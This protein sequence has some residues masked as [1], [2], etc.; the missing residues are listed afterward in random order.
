M[1]KKNYKYMFLTIYLFL[2]TLSFSDENINYILKN[3]DKPFTGMTSFFR[4]RSFYKD[5]KPTG[6]W[7][8]FYENGDLK[9]IENWENGLLNGKYIIYKKNRV[10]IIEQSFFNGKEHGKY[11][12][13][14]ENKKIHILGEFNNGKPCGEWEFYNEEG[15]LYGRNNFKK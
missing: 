4:D 11:V 7:L 9:S 15:I 12:I 6:K 13:Y 3:K 10:K 1:I 5:G 8:S 14:H 2:T